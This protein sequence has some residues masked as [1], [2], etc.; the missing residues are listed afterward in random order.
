MEIGTFYVRFSGIFSIKKQDKLAMASSIET[1]VPFLDNEFVDLAL[2]IRNKDLIRRRGYKW[3]GKF[4]VKELCADIFGSKFSFRNKMGFAIPLKEFFK[5]EGFRIRWH[6][7][8]LPS[9]EKRGLFQ[10]QRLSYL[11]RQLL[12]S[13]I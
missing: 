4:L 1:R 3:H 10:T 7:E 8:I 5:S 12:N 6:K 2:R 9:I 11:R 13:K